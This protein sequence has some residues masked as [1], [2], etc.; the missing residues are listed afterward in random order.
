MLPSVGPSGVGSLLD[1]ALPQAAPA[2]V[3]GQNN[4]P[5]QGQVTNPQLMAAMQPQ[6]PMSPFANPQDPTMQPQPQTQQPFSP[7]AQPQ[8]PR[9]Y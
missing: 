6:G 8:P 7:Y 4:I 5:A 1:R 2:P 3:P 9:L